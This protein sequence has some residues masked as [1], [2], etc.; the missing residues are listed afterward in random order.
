MRPLLPL[1]VL[2]ASPLLTRA[3]CDTVRLAKAGWSIV[4]VDS[5]ELTGEG[6]NNGH[7]AQAID[8]D[9]L[10]FWHTQWQGAQPG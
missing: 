3:Q 6:A 2:A 10:T 4:Y 8:G 9:S 7:A 5:Q 1:L